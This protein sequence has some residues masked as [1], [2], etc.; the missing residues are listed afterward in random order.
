MLSLCPDDTADCRTPSRPIRPSAAT[1]ISYLCNRSPLSEDPRVTRPLPVVES[2]SW[3]RRRA[4]KDTPIDQCIT[5]VIHWHEGS[6]AE[7]AHLQWDDANVQHIAE[8]NVAPQEVEDVCFGVHLSRRESNQRYV[9][10][11]QT[12]DG[13]YLNVVV[14]RIGKGLFRP[15]TAFEMS[16][17]YKR[18]Y[19]RRVGK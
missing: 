14:E 16:D 13:R 17:D 8:H 4:P 5:Y 12:G 18:S 10:S 1:R 6:S 11:G 19:R 2:S 3:V 9:L 7:I 15:I